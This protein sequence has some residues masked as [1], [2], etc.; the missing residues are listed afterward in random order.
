MPAHYNRDEDD[1]LI[2]EEGYRPNVGIILV[3]PEGK[4]FLGKRINQDAW[5]FPQGGI[6][7][8]E[9]PQQALFRELKEEV[10]LNPADVRVLG[11]TRDWLRYDLPPQYVRHHNRPVCI[12][13]KQIW[14]MVGL[15]GDESRIRLDQHHHPEF[16]SYRWVDYWVPVQEV[17]EFK[18]SVYQQALTELE[19]AMK[20]LWLPH[21]P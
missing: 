1:A 12:G 21:A 6:H 14:F 8:N 18:R 16:E 15:V 7:P 9:T 3:N 11:R 20:R 2:D 17:V 4:L 13:Q 5:Q 10:G 19:E